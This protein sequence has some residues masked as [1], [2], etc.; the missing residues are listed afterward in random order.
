MEFA[1]EVGQRIVGILHRGAYR[2]GTHFPGACMTVPQASQ[3][4]RAVL[5]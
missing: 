3:V 4:R 2:V 1:G 5:E